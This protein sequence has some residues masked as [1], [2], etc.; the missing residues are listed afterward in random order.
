MVCTHLHPTARIVAGNIG[1]MPPLIHP[2]LSAPSR[3][4][5]LHR[6][7]LLATDFALPSSEKTA[8]WIIRVRPW[9]MA[10][11]TAHQQRRIG[12][13]AEDL[14]RAILTSLATS[15]LALRV[16]RVWPWPMVEGAAR[17]QRRHE[18]VGAT[19]KMGKGGSMSKIGR[20]LNSRWVR[21]WDPKPKRQSQSF[22]RSYTS[23][24]RLFLPTLFH[25]LEVVYLGDLI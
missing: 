9:L 23:V 5:L 14:L 12:G 6:I 2:F 15:T 7:D 11:G 25:C 20:R 4:P 17:R 16:D 1:T 8:L 24:C 19:L 18:R 13:T 21:G 10:E 22:S 3:P